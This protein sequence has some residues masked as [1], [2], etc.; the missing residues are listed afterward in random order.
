MPE[1]FAGVVGGDHRDGFG[2]CGVAAGVHPA[3]DAE[4][5]RE[6]WF[7]HRA[8]AGVEVLVGGGVLSGDGDQRGSGDGLR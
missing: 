8:A 6:D 5:V 2:L 7:D 4:Q 3:V 1:V